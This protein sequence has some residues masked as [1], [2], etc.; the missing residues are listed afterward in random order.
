[1][2]KYMIQVVEQ[3]IIE[4]EANSKEEAEVKAFESDAWQT[5]V[6]DYQV[7]V[8]STNN[9]TEIFDLFQLDDLAAGANGI[10]A[11]DLEPDENIIRSSN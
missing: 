8:L 7:S 3:R 2:S 9:P 1:M 10:S 11:S 4:V 6:R 5:F